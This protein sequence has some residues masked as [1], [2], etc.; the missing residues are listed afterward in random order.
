MAISIRAPLILLLGALAGGC[1]TPQ[2]PVYDETE[3][4]KFDPVTQYDFQPLAN[5]APG[6]NL[7]LWSGKPKLVIGE[8]LGLQYRAG[9]N[10]Y[11]SLYE[12]GSSGSVGQLFENRPI[13]Q[14]QTL[15]FPALG[16]DYAYKLAPPPGAEHFILVATTQPLHW[17]APAD[18]GQQNGPLTKLHFTPSELIDRLGSVL[19]RHHPNNWNST[20]LSLPLDRAWR[21]K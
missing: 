1:A 12:I 4:A 18:R 5:P 19:K 9:A 13:T 7:Q 14:G 17:I 16:S 15:A 10:A 2:K 8:M 20:T 6:F 11:V 21:A 3:A